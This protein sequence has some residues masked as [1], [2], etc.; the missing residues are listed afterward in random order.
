MFISFNLMNNFEFYIQLQNIYTWIHI[1]CKANLSKYEA[2][3]LYNPLIKMSQT[4]KNG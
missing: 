3:T 2:L 4:N 1:K